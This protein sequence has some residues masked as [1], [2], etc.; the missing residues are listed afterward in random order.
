MSGYSH[1]VGDL[2]YRVLVGIT[3]IIKKCWNSLYHIAYTDS[4]IGSENNSEVDP[5]VSNESETRLEKTKY[6]HAVV[7]KGYSNQDSTLMLTIRDSL[8]GQKVFGD[9]TQPGEYE[10]ESKLTEKS[11]QWNLASENCYYFEFL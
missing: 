9:Q 10:I 5:E 3:Y 6:Y 4:E 8:S 11:N 7:M 2:F 1:I